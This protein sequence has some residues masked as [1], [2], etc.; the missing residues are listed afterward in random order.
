MGR[1]GFVLSSDVIRALTHDGVISG[2]ATSKSAMK[3]VQ[4]AFDSWADES[5]LPFAHISRTLAC[6]LD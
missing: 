6:S 5:G 2:P 3:A 4:A 1:D